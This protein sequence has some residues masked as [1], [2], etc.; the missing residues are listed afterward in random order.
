MSDEQIK[1]TNGRQWI[2]ARG[3]YEAVSAEIADE[4]L[5]ALVDAERDLSDYQDGHLHGSLENWA[6][7]ALGRFRAAIARAIQEGK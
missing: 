1:V 5:R 7:L 3:G 6:G 4:L 2:G